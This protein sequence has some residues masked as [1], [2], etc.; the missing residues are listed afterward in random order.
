MAIADVCI[1]ARNEI[2]R[3]NKESL[4][5]GILVTVMDQVEKTDL[6]LKALMEQNEILKE[7]NRIILDT[8]KSLLEKIGKST[9][10]TKKE[11]VKIK[12]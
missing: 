11:E 4:M 6:I 8:N 5:A 9:C 10:E 2:G 12:K 3:V 1:Q 7:Q